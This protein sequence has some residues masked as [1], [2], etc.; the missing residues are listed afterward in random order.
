L[1][2]AVRPRLLPI[3]VIRGLTFADEGRSKVHHT[4]LRLRYKMDIATW[5]M[6][7]A[8]YKM[9]IAGYPPRFFI[10]SNLCG[11]Y[12]AIYFLLRK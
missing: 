11:L 3:R 8:T 7:I 2:A 12:Q 9:D 4:I 10:S 1:V 6:D 5:K